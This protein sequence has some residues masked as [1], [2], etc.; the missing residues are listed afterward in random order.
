MVKLILPRNLLTGKPGQVYHPIKVESI[1]LPKLK[2]NEVLVKLY[3]AALN[4]RDVFIRQS[5]L[6]PSTLASSSADR[7]L[8]TGL[9]PGI[10]FGKPTSAYSTS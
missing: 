5:Q 2:E 7:L 10:Q 6:D 3:A 9:Y 4:H 1:P 8:H